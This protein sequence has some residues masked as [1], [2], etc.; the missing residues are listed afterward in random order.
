MR[1][2]IMTLTL[3][4]KKSTLSKNDTKRNGSQKIRLELRQNF[5]F[6][7]P[8]SSL[9]KATAD[10]TYKEQGAVMGLFSAESWTACLCL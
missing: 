3:A 8:Q 9:S 10:C 4:I 2:T 1:L 5:F 6:I 7:C